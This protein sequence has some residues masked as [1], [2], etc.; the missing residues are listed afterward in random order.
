MTFTAVGSL[1]SSTASSFSLTPSAVGDFIIVGVLAGF[2]TGSSAS[3]ATAL[4][5]SNVTWSVLVAHTA[6]T[7]STGAETIFLGKVTS[8]SAA[9]VT[10][11][12]NSGSPQT[13]TAWQEFSN[14][15]GNSAVTLDVSGTV[16]V[17]SSAHFPS[18]TP[19][20][21]SGELYW[22]YLWDNGTGTAGSTTGYTYQFDANGNPMA[23]NANCGSG[24]QA[25]NIG[26]TSDGVSGIAVLLYEAVTSFSGAASLSGSGTLTSA[27]I[28]TQ[29]ASATLSGSGTLTAAGAAST[30]AS[31]ALFGQGALTADATVFVPGAGSANLSG[32]GSLT[33]SRAVTYQQAVPLS[34]TGTLSAQETGI[35]QESVPLSGTGTLTVAGSAALKFTAGLFGAGFLSIPQVA[36]GLV[37]GIGGGA[38]PFALPGSSQVAVAPPGS[39]NWQ[40]IGTLGQVTALT[41][42]YVCPGGADKMSCTVMVPASYQSQLFYPG[43]QVKIVRG[44]H[45]I[46]HGKLDQPQ[47]QAGRGW[48]LTA[49]GNGNRGQDFNAYYAIGWPGSEPDEVISRAIIR[50]LPWASPGYNSAPFASQ[51]WL[52]QPVDAGSQKVSDFLNMICSRGGLT[53]YVNSQPGGIYAADDLQIFPLPTVPTRLLVCTTPV[54]RTLGGYTNYI[55]IRYLATADNTSTSTAATYGYVAATNPASIAAHG[56]LESYLDISDAPVMTS[57]QAQAVGNFILSVYVAASFGGPFSVSYGQLLNMGGQAIDPGTDQAGSMVK[58]VLADSA[59]GG[60]VD[61]SQPVTFII[62]SYEWDD[63][64]Q[65]AKVSPYQTLDESLSALMAAEKQSLK[66]LTVASA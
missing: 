22:S 19:G 51:F 42:S 16:D 52:G 54:P 27:G 40:W 6:F 21:G 36:G 47:F 7:A 58:L 46:W 50:G 61:A 34:G 13:R 37:N 32:S 38:T 10:I 31:A 15:L 33:V 35:T 63:F 49:V 29:P 2:P 55:L 48:T 8:T 57:A 24:A 20:H 45:D 5:S 41:Y 4:S 39:A 17:A 66:P 11:T 14:T 26:D 43:W 65:V 23:Y 56:Q 44:G 18:I 62:G 53:W 12:F 30:L 28:V 59:Y 3:Y 1:H 25:P 60:S 64:S 9:T